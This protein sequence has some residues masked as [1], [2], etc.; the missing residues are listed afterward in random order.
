MSNG[1][2]ENVDFDDFAIFCN[3]GH[4]GFLPNPNL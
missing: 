1:S 3:G 2:G 4:R